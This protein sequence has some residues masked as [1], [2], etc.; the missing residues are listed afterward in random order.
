MADMLPASLDQGRP[1]LRPS[2]GCRRPDLHS[3]VVQSVIPRLHAALQKDLQRPLHHLISAKVSLRDE[4]VEFAEH[5]LS[6]E[7]DAACDR[8]DSLRRRGC[9]LESIYLELLVPT[10]RHLREL[11]SDDCC[12]FADV[13]FAL[14]NLQG[15]LRRYATD[16]LGEA[17][18]REY[19]ARVLLVAPSGDG[20]DALTPMF[21]LVLTS[22]FFRR[23]G[24]ETAIE[25]DLN[26]DAFGRTVHE[27][28]DLVE[29][30]AAND[31]QLDDI[32]SGIRRI[33]RG[34]PNRSLGVIVC[35][36]IFSDRPDYIRLV[37][38]DLMASDPLSSLSEADSFVMRRAPPPRLS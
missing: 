19:G 38:A 21:G 1:N 37:G 2:S 34:S 15:I 25:R 8:V 31:S 33:R 18:T 32:A 29:V 9:S 35:G 24:W 10:A 23:G 17:T 7:Q 27:W 22:Q 6:G 30:L 11:W 26:C 4:V 12:G 14:A 13:T 3:T 20:I 36:K 16:F 28:F 5:L